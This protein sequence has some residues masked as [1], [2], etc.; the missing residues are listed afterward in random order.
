M[1]TVIW[2]LRRVEAC[3][4]RLGWQKV[5][6]AIAERLV[7]KGDALPRNARKLE[8]PDRS[9]PASLRDKLAGGQAG[10]D[11]DDGPGSDPDG[12]KEDAKPKRGKLRGAGGKGE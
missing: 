8:A 6:D 9:W 5:D 11:P 4:G 10:A 1:A 2:M 7:K 12:G 3:R